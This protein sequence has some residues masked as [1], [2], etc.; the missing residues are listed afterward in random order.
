MTRVSAIVVAAGKGSRFNSRVSKPL[1]K[2]NGAPLVLFSLKVFLRHPRVFEIIV[3]ANADNEDAL[4]ALIRRE[5]I[6]KVRALVRGG[7]RRQDSVRNGLQAVRKDAD[8]VLVHDAARPFVS[9]GLI[10]R[11]IN[12]A[13]KYKA[14]IPASPVISTI[15]KVDKAGNVIATVDRSNLW[16]VHTPQAFDKALLIKAFQG[17]GRTKVTDEAMLIEKM[18]KKVRVV[19]DS[20]MNIKITT[21]EDLCIAQALAKRFA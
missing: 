5:R 10:T 8:I 12:K 21:P 16:Q 11:L 13:R 20:S 17:F 2:L 6:T 7:L 15:K 19:K 18:G 14:A 4:R 9:A 1:A 3:V